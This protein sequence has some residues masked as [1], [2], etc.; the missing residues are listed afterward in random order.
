MGFLLALMYPLSSFADI[1]FYVSPDGDNAFFIEGDDI[2]DTESVEITVVYDSTILANP[3]VSLE[4]GT[5]TNIL[6]PNPGILTFKANRGDN[7]NHSFEAHLNFDRMWDS[8]GGLFSVTG[9]IM[10]PDGTISPSRTNLNTSIPSLLTFASNDGGTASTPEK[11]PATEETASSGN[12]PDILMKAEKSV[13]QRFKEFKG[14]RG[15]KAFVALFERSPRDI[16]VQEPPIV[17]SDGKTCAMIRIAQQPKGRDSP[18]FVL[19]DAKLV[20]LE[21]EG[22]KSWIITALPKEGTCN[23]S[24]LIK[25]DKEIIEFPLVVAPPVKIH[26]GITERNFVAELDRFIS[27]QVGGGKGENDP[28]WYIKYEYI[29]TANYLASSE[30]HPAKMKSEQASL[31]INAK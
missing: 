3:R 29:F 15:L 11:S 16:F 2:K 20:H 5:V 26:N 7:T 22:E 21:K 23:A 10:E 14:E 13:V 8:Q 24:L 1:T 18:N 31:V 12:R 28:L 9:K 6:N 25:L 19:S 27:A 4:G 17:L 30:N